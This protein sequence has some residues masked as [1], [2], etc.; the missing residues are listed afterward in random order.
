MEG[1]KRVL[2][3]PELAPG[4]L[5]VGQDAAA[6]EAVPR[7]R[8][9]FSSAF[10]A[11]TVFVGRP[12]GRVICP[13]C[14]DVFRDR[15]GRPNPPPPRSMLPVATLAYASHKPQGGSPHSPPVPPPPP[16]G[17]FL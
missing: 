3:L 12:E 6:L 16:G 4:E 1:R 5:K 13:Q 9:L 10:G 17:L 8:A 7:K 14:K 15:E 11:P 2:E